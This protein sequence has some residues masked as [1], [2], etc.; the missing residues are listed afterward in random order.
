MARSLCPQNLMNVSILVTL[1][2]SKTLGFPPCGLLFPCGFDQGE[3]FFHA[4]GCRVTLIGGAS[5][6]SHRLVPADFR[7]CS[8]QGLGRTGIPWREASTAPGTL[9]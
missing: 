9:S 1:L 8:G 2:Q 7:G 5:V 6:G 3:L 4:T